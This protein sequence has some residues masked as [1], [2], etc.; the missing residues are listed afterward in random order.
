M[1]ASCF[2]DPGAATWSGAS[3]LFADVAGSAKLYAKLGDAEAAYAVERCVKRMER[4]VEGFRGRVVK[5]AGGELMAVFAGPED[6]VHAAGDMLQRID[7]LPPVSGVKLPFASAFIMGRRPREG[8]SS[9]AT[10]SGG[11]RASPAGARAGQA[12]TGGDTVARLPE[13]L[14]LSMRALEPGSDRKR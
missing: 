6:V 4:S 11:R 14:Q 5:L 13:L 9:P 10:P 12:L 3:V 2:P 1:P 8:A 7:D